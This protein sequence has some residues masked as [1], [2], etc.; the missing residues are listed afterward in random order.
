M[1]KLKWI[2]NCTNP[3]IYRE[4]YPEWLRGKIIGEP[5]ATAA[6]T[7]EEVR[8]MSMVGVYVEEE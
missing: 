5:K 7:T 8:A 2:T 3:G 4:T 1:A 6:Y